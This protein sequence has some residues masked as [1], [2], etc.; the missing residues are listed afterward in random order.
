[1][2][3]LLPAITFDQKSK[4]RLG[5]VQVVPDATRCMQCGICSYSCP[6]GID[7]RAYAWRGLPVND[8]ACL[9]CGQCVARCLRRAL[10]FESI[11]LAH[12]AE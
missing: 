4:H 9:A 5:V 6:A 10:R 7:V 3:S 1:M 12:P 2:L 8:T 11:Q